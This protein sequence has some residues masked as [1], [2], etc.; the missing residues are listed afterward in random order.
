MRLSPQSLNLS[1]AIVRTVPEAKVIRIL[2]SPGDVSGLER[3]LDRV[4]YKVSQISNTT[5]NHTM[6]LKGSAGT[7]KTHL[8][9]DFARQRVDADA[10]VVLLM[11]QRFTDTGDP[12]RQL[13]EQ[14][15]MHGETPDTFVGAWRQRLNR[16]TPARC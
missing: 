11:G 3:E 16:P 4:S 6:I 8:M 7:G 2:A 13:L 12:W 9:C 5:N 15:G 1:K 14:V 10:P